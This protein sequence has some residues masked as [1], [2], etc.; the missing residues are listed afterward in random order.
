MFSNILNF[1]SSI[2]R[3]LQEAI[4]VLDTEDPVTREHVTDILQGLCEQILVTLRVLAQDDPSNPI[5][6]HLKRLLMA[7]KSLM[8]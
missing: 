7:A 3:Y 4:V 5:Q 2:F 8:K 1:S 6:R